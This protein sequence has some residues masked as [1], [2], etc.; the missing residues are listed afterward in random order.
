M[1][2]THPAQAQAVR[3]ESYLS[4][5]TRAPRGFTFYDGP[6]MLTGER[7]IGI[8]LV[9]SSNRK[10]GDM[11]QT[12]ILRADMRPTDAVRIGAD[13]AICGMCP[14]RP[15]LG[16]ACYVVV[17]QGPTVVFKTWQRG[18]Y[19]ARSAEDIG[20]DIAGRPVRL[21]TYGDPAAIPARHWE[22]LTAHASKRTGYTHQW[23][24]EGFQDAAQLPRITALCMA[25]V[26]DEDGARAAHSAGLRYFRV[27]RADAPMLPGEFVCPASDEAGKR[28]TCAQCGAC[29]GSA[30]GASRASPVII[31]HGSRAPRRTIQIQSIA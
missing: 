22:D 21:G 19:P 27:R 29:D 10:T 14:Q 9:H 4:I 17:C 5:K 25:S 18:A 15:A 7:I 11:V 24:V 8:A 12:Y 6:S 31:A 16:G 3:I 2:S 13:V 28:K 23:R 26:E 20:A 30:R 1:T